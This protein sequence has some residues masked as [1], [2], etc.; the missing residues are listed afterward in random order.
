MA[1]VLGGLFLVNMAAKKLTLLPLII[2]KNSITSNNILNKKF[3]IS[4]GG[5]TMC[6]W[7]HQDKY[8]S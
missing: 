8:K 4:F 2:L 1:V 3:I 5:A 7:V 6:R